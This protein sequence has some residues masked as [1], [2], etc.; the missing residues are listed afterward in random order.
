M[1][2]Y[3]VVFCFLCFPVV[4]SFF[5]NLTEITNFAIVVTSVGFHWFR[6]GICWLSLVGVGFP[7]KDIT[8]VHVLLNCGYRA[9]HAPGIAQEKRWLGSSTWPTTPPSWSLL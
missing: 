2:I 1:F 9:A 4:S 8:G 6:A 7:L 3:D 5:L